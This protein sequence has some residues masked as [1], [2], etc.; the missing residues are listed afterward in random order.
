[1][2][3]AQQKTDTTSGTLIA[4]FSGSVFEPYG[5]EDPETFLGV[6]GSQLV[7]V[8][9]NSEDDDAAVIAMVRDGA[10]VR[11][12]LAEEINFNASPEEKLGA[13]VW[14]SADGE[15][16]AAFIG[17][18]V[19]AGDAE[20]VVKCLEAKQSGAGAFAGFAASDAVAFTVGRETGT[21][22]KLVEAFFGRK[23]ESPTVVISY[24]TETRVNRQG[25]ERQTVSDFGLIGAI[26]ERLVPE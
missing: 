17:D 5:I 21:L 25:I 26:I 3:T 1:M 11:R 24:S 16:A 20:T 9:L 18:V 23:E 10:A 13:Q 14:R 4:A 19:I 8:K 6:V 22:E 15:T 12:S 7:T 2:L